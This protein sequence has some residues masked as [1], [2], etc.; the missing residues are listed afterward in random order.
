[1]LT[2]DSST[3]GSDGNWSVH[4]DGKEVEAVLDLAPGV[5]FAERYEILQS[6]GQGGMGAVYKA[7]DQEVDR[8]VALKVIR[9]E[10]A[11]NPEILRRFKQELILARQVTHKNVIRI[12]ELGEASGTRFIT[13]QFIEGRTLAARVREAGKLSPE[14]ATQVMEQVFLALEAAHAEGVVHRDLKPENIMI[15]AQGRAYV[16]DFGIARTMGDDGMT[17]TGAVLGT[18]DYMSPEQVLGQHVD[19]RSD[20][21]TTGIIF[22]QLLTGDKPFKA[23]SA[24][25]L[26]L[27]RT[28]G[29]PRPVTEIDPGVPEALSRI[30]SKCLETA[31]EH[32]YQSA[33]EVLE[34]LRNW[35]TGGIVPE[36]AWPPKT[37][38]VQLPRR[39]WAFL[40]GI[41][42]TVIAVV[43]LA[44]LFRHKIFSP[45]NT[46]P[47]APVPA[48]SLAVLPFQ[49]ASGDPSLDWLGGTTAELLR[50]T[51]GQSSRVHELSNDRV[52]QVLSD[53][54]IAAGS[55]SDAANLPRFAT[56]SNADAVVHGSFSKSGDKIRFD[57][58]VDDVKGH[59]SKTVHAEAGSQKELLPAIVAL[60]ASVR[61]DLGVSPDVL[62]ELGE[63]SFH[64]SSDSLPALRAYYEGVE[65]ADEGTNSQAVQRLQAA[66][67]ED[68]KFAFAFSELGMVF[69][70][71]GEDEQAQKYVRQSQELS[72]S[73]P[74]FEKSW[75]QARHDAV[76][77][78]FDKAGSAYET[79]TR[80][81]PDNVE[82]QSEFAHLEEALGAFDK[83]RVGFAEVLALDPARVDALL[84]AG[85]VEIELGNVQASFDFLTRAQSLAIELASDEE[86]AKILQALGVAY[87]QANRPQDALKSYQE[88]LAIKRRL[89]LK[90]GIADSLEAIAQT[91]NALGKTDE[92]LAGYNEALRIRREIGDKAGTGDVELDLALFYS[93]HG[94]FDEAMKLYKDSLQ[95]YTSVGNEPNRGLA[96]NS[97]GS[98]Y[99]NLGDYVNAQTYLSQALAVREKLNVPAD[100]ADTLHN[101]AEVSTHTGNYDQALTQYLRALELRR[102]VNDKH[103]AAVESCALG[104]LFGYQGRFGAALHS[105]QESVQ[106]LRET[107]EQGYYMTEALI[108]F[109]KAQAEI[110]QSE[111]ARKTLEDAE[112]HA[113]EAGNQKQMA[114]ALSE[115]GHNALYQGDFKSASNFYQQAQSIA[116]K[117]ND[118]ELLLLTKADSAML[119]AIQ[120]PSAAGVNNLRQLATEADSF[121]VRYLS[122]ECSLHLA[123][124]LIS[125]KQ[126]SQ[127]IDELQRTLNRSDK[128]GSRSLSAQCHY[129]LAR[130]YQLTNKPDEATSQLNEAR[131]IV[132]DI[133]AE[134]GSD[135]VL[136]RKDLALISSASPA[137]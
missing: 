83:A 72:E 31:P 105:E 36:V 26:M 19:A 10:L 74:P 7:Q 57:G 33:S 61:S 103:G 13:M 52:R 65:L 51:I 56:A 126:Y 54:R 1:M 131:R 116:S 39:N 132:S 5:L 98:T 77:T 99:L 121:G 102:S 53:L 37:Q 124:A 32:R 122:V 23:D 117:A 68:P 42:T 110:G 84:S 119:V 136:A 60:G 107:Q 125:T 114:Q 45:A 86:Q 93:D 79:L 62:K 71:M 9:P 35:R 137:D 21:Y 55:V 11:S 48:F 108:E 85:R 44:V 16:M 67:T 130:C 100:L 46:Q 70:N 20:L 111:E 63:Q 90:K 75:I 27:L 12:Y 64:P 4:V 82:L 49:N 127:A 40:A 96:L 123:E 8:V 43:V 24:V 30:I 59:H 34:D 135:S 66:T 22:Y 113:K 18:P 109:G 106:T 129:F 76:L 50:G 47:A 80:N 2:M 28:Q 115:L 69:A 133:R 120:N 73:L 29:P 38:E 101:L 6:L 14:E 81:S 88:S 92:V 89:G 25:A 15:D 128:L 112:N 78:N 134:A 3:E 41:A 87:S 97:I 104:A 118:R 91:N 17:K 58:T 94:K 95:I